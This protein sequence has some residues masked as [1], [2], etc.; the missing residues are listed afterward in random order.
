MDGGLCRSR[1]GKGKG[2]TESVSRVRRPA[3][4][5]SSGR[6]Q[7][8]V[9]WAADGAW[10][11]GA[12]KFAGDSTGTRAQSRCETRLQGGRRTVPKGEK[13]TGQLDPSGAIT[14]ARSFATSGRSGPASRGAGI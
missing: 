1:C 14:L 3:T 10:R 2:A 4:G 11:S 5:S 12:G 8:Q 6:Y 13:P 7:D 9:A